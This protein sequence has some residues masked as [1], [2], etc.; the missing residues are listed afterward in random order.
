MMLK[1]AKNRN[2]VKCNGPKL[3]F[4]KRKKLGESVFQN[5]YNREEQNKKKKKE[6]VGMPKK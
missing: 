2:N 6:S 5:A 3:K 1:S 4:K